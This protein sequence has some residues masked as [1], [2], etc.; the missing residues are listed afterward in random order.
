MEINT[1]NVQQRL[2]LTHTHTHTQ[3]TWQKHRENTRENNQER[4][5]RITRRENSRRA[6]SAKFYITFDNN[7]NPVTKGRYK[8]TFISTVSPNCPSDEGGQHMTLKQTL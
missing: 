8:F 7:T 5:L 3:S 6:C 4:P 2:A 1:H